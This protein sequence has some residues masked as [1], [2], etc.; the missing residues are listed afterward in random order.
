[1]IFN[2][3]VPAKSVE[4]LTASMTPLDNVTYTEGITGLDTATLSLAAQAISDLT[5]VTSDTMTLY[6]DGGSVHRRISV[7]DQVTIP[8]NGVDYGFHIIGFN[9]DDLT[10]PAAY[11]T[12]T[13]TCKAGITLDMLELWSEAYAANPTQSNVGGWRESA[14]RTEVMPMLEGYMPQAWRSVIKP[15]SKL[16]GKGGGGAD[17]DV[18]AVSDRCFILSEMEVNGKV[19]RSYIGEGTQYARFKAVNKPATRIKTQNGTGIEWWLRSPVK[20]DSFTNAWCY[21]N[22]R[23]YF[24]YSYADTAYGISYAFCV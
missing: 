2:L 12:I 3:S 8:L 4:A 13:A 7:N 24:G 23:G 10:D 21:I 19:V 5:S 17:T 20:G 1:M 22:P 14:L 6:V 16:A 18:E 11:G 15:V 9:H